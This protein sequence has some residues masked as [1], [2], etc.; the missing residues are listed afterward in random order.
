MMG[1]VPTN[2]KRGMIEKQEIGTRRHSAKQNKTCQ[3]EPQ[4][5]EWKR[6]NF[7]KMFISG[8]RGG[9]VSIAVWRFE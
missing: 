6:R 8:F 4:A 9:W 7:G 2:Q 5:G 3:K 1:K